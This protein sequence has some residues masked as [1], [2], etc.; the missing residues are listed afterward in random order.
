MVFS[1]IAAAGN[2]AASCAACTPLIAV[3]LQGEH[4]YL[5]SSSYLQVA[6]TVS[7]HR[8]GVCSGVISKAVMT[9][10]T[11]SK[12]TKGTTACKQ[13]QWGVK[14]NW[15]RRWEG[16]RDLRSHL[17]VQ[18]CCSR[19]SES[20]VLYCVPYA[21]CQLL[22]LA[23]AVAF[24]AAFRGKQ[25]RPC[26]QAVNH[27]VLLQSVYIL[28][29]GWHGISNDTNMLVNHVVF[30]QPTSK[31]SRRLCNITP[32]WFRT[33]ALFIKLKHLD[34]TFSVIYAR[35]WPGLWVL[36]R[37]LWGKAFSGFPV[38]VLWLLSSQLLWGKWWR[39]E[40]S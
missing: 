39:L 13:E 28:R 18:R 12:H 22:W 9:G 15:K 14:T 4:I 19:T 16:W 36:D 10:F 20:R 31:M 7:R 40:D 29:S 1:T 8:T 21:C 33:S 2:M 27:T 23:F 35:L 6:V 26:S 30:F 5:L 37:I 25:E 3:V 32:L 34:G 38:D 11:V 17:R 24:L